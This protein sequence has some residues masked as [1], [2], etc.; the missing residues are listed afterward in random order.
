MFGWSRFSKVGFWFGLVW[1][2]WCGA[3]G[4]GVGWGVALKFGSLRISDDA[5]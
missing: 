5:E 3:C 2:G 4:V 1:L